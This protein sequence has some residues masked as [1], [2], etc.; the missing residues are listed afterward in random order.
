MGISVSA[1][2]EALLMGWKEAEPLVIGEGGLSFESL[3]VPAKRAG[4][5]FELLDYV[6]PYGITVFNQVQIPD[7]S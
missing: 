6:D 2:S 7:R 4:E 3:Y 1:W 5:E